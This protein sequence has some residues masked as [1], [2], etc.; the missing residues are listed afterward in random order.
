MDFRTTLFCSL[1][2][3]I[4]SE[5]FYPQYRERYAVFFNIKEKRELILK[6][7]VK[8]EKEIEKQV[9]TK[10]SDTSTVIRKFYYDKKG[11]LARYEFYNDDLELI[12]T[13]GCDFYKDE[14]R[15]TLEV[16]VKGKLTT[17]REYDD[18]GNTTLEI[19]I[20]GEVKDTVEQ[21]EYTY[22]SINDVK[23]LT[24]IT[25]LH[26]NS[27]IENCTKYIFD[28]DSLGR[29]IYRRD[30]WSNGNLS[31][32]KHWD[33]DSLNGYTKSFFSDG[34]RGGSALYKFDEEGNILE[35]KSYIPELNSTET[36]IHEYNKEGKLTLYI[37]QLQDFYY[38]GEIK[39][40]NNGNFL[41]SKLF[42]N[43]ILNSYR[44]STYYNNELPEETIEED[45]RQGSKI[46]K[47]YIY[48]FY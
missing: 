25:V 27:D 18:E 30:Y 6:L 42:E 31:M 43:E 24:S 34:E 12:P 5:L 39:Y 44:T 20:N 26:K 36:T 13:S 40:D 23:L 11:N 3:I 19:N 29:I 47:N 28:Y 7:G 14:K 9:K 16:F 38:K 46:I 41:E 37:N 48:E 15:N 2:I 35:E 10:S 17:R 33:Y 22:T 32:E 1:I 45:Y 8:T 4:A 21:N